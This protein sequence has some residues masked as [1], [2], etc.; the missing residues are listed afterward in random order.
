MNEI[1]QIGA[2]VATPLG[3][4]GFA[5]GLAAFV[6]FRRLKHKEHQLDSLPP[7]DRAHA[8][9]KSLTRYGIGGDGLSPG[10]KAKLLHEEMERR[11]WLSRLALILFAIVFVICLMIV[12]AAYV[13]AETTHPREKTVQVQ[14]MKGGEELAVDFD[15]D[16]YVPN[17]GQIQDRGTEGRASLR[18]IPSSLSELTVFSVLCREGKY[19][20]AAGGKHAYPLEKGELLLIEMVL[21]GCDQ[22]PQEIIFP[23]PAAYIPAK[24]QLAERPVIAAERVRLRITNRTQEDVTLLLFNCTPPVGNSDRSL[25]SRWVVEP[26]DHGESKWIKRFRPD[27]CGWFAFFVRT[28]DGRVFPLGNKNVFTEEEPKLAVVRLERDSYKLSEP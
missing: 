25:V 20:P 26:F 5:C 22:P 6:Y 4:I 17:R 28:S 15:I 12:T 1:L 3:L 16:Y 7:Q 27:S 21:D 23:D 14:L 24:E 8:I 11:F 19:C 2:N 18:G 9:D 13:V 10:Q